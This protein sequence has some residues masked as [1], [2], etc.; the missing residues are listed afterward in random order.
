MERIAID[1][2]EPLAQAMIVNRSAIIGIVQMM[3]IDGCKSSQD[4]RATLK[5]ASLINASQDVLGAKRMTLDG[6]FLSWQQLF[7]REVT[8]FTERSHTAGVG[9]EAT[10]AGAKRP[11]KELGISPVRARLELG[12]VYVVLFDERLDFSRAR[13]GVLIGGDKPVVS[14]MRLKPVSQGT[15]WVAV[16]RCRT[17]R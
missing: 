16:I 10:D 7:P 9:W 1:S 12:H 11:F 17:V 3:I 6:E 13:A 15:A 4:H 8:C 14:R 2:P 5:R